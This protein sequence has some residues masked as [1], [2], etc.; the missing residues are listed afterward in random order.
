MEVIIQQNADLASVIAARIVGRLVREKPGA[1]LGLATGS[2]P[3]R[4]YRELVRMHREEGLDFSR[5]T[6]FNLDEYVGLS[7]DHPASY[8]VF[9]QENLFKHINI[10]ASNVHIPDGTANDIPAHCI[11]Y[12][13]AIAAA[14]GIDLQVLGVGSDGH[15]GFNEP[16][17][18]LASRTRIKTLTEETR[19]DNSCFFASL[20]DVPRHCIT[21]G[22]GTILDSRVCL[23]MAFGSA[24]ANAV[25][26][27]VE[28]P[29]TAMIP[30]SALQLHRHV[31]VLVDD[32]AAIGLEKVDY[33][34][35][36]YANKPE[37]QSYR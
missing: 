32:A 35:W 20:N 17:S 4:L 31:H 6:T 11:A 29:I 19:R 15:L 36:V 8:R 12:E 24:K 23:L 28:G 14:G 37:W 1:V 9:M 27:S 22:M 26:K 5:V 13:E 21:M 3:L 16:T 18:S 34:R 25:A 2:T 7:P 30:G 33:Y 10:Q